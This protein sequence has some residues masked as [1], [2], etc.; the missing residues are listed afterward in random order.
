M[1]VIIIGGGHNG[2]AAAT[3]LARAGRKVTVLEA[4]DHVGG[5]CARSTFGD[6]GQ[7][8][9]PGLLHDTRGVRDALIDVLDLGRHGLKRG[10]AVRICAPS[11]EGDTLWLQGDGIE[12]ADDDVANMK[13]FRAF[14]AR[15]APVLNDMMNKPPPDPTGAV[16]PLLLTGLKVRRLGSSDMMELIRVAPM[17]VADWMRDTFASER[18]RAAVALPALEASFNGPWSAGSAASLLIR[19]AT[20]SAPIAGG[21]A[22]LID[23]LKKAAEAAGATIRCQ[24]VVK[25]IDVKG[26]DVTG[27]TLEDGE[28]LDG[29]VLS[30]VDPKRTF[31]DLV[32]AYRLPDGLANDVRVLRSRGT[33]A[34]VHLA[35]EG[36]LQ[37]DGSDVEVL[38]TGESLDAIEQAFDAVKYRRF[39]ERPTLDAW[40]L[41]AEGHS[42]L[43]IVA[44]YAAYDLEGGWNDAQRDALGEAVI[45]EL[46]RYVPDV[47]ERI[48]A[49]EVLTPADIATRHRLSGG[50][51]YHA[52]HAPDQLLFMRPSVDCG[53]YQT[54]L[55]GLWLGGSGSHP[56]GGATCAPGALAARAMLR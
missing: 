46:E 6:E 29:V 53:H 52:E 22:A 54:P 18:L 19:E 45:A 28:T 25:A 23:A 13:R 56:G 41:P 49:R 17:C 4:R 31:L 9:V 21:P 27:V 10:P 55:R 36:T 7:Y 15:V 35:I 33:T 26:M 47:R 1:S 38:R 51:P 11:V 50:H 20:A 39:S 14:I 12:G 2:L 5:V 24:A 30:T 37:I 32:G 40:V 34:K 43:S 44:H 8:E 3:M 42:V 16:W 48:V